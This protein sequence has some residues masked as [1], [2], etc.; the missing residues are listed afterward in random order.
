MPLQFGCRP[1]DIVSHDRSP[2]AYLALW[3]IID[4][5]N[6]FTLSRYRQLFL[7][8]HARQLTQDSHGI[9]SAAKETIKRGRPNERTASRM[10]LIA[11]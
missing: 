8:T 4:R 2:I 5:S 7:P 3:K 9:E 11:V 6:S 1:C 10:R